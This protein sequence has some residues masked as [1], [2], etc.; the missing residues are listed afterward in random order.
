MSGSS[1]WRDSGAASKLAGCGDALGGKLYDAWRAAPWATQSGAT[2]VKKSERRVV[3]EDIID[4]A[5]KRLQ[6]TEPGLSYEQAYARALDTD[7]I[8]QL[9]YTAGNHRKPSGTQ[10]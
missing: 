3:G 4:G 7:P 5:A 10:G 1:S 9:A 2:A 6:A 8:A